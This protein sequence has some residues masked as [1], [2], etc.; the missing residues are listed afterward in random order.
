MRKQITAYLASIVFVGVAP[1]ALALGGILNLTVAAALALSLPIFIAQTGAI[2]YFLSGLKTFQPGLK[3]AYYFF[4]AGLAMFSVGQL[5]LPAV[6][7]LN[8]LNIQTNGLGPLFILYCFGTFVMYI[9]VRKFAKLLQT[10][11]FP[12][13]PLAL[14]VAITAI[15]TGLSWF[16]PHTGADKVG[17]TFFF[18]LL[19]FS[20]ASSMVAALVG[21]R[22]RQV[23]GAAYKPAI[24]WLVAGL[25]MIAFYY[26]QAAF[27]QGIGASVE[28]LKWFDTYN[29][30][31]WPSIAGS[32]FLL[33]AGQLFKLVGLRYGTLP[34]PANELDIVTYVANLP[35]DPR[36]ID[37]IIDTVRRLTASRQTSNAL[38]AVEKAKLLEIYLKIEEYLVTQE[39][40]RKFT[41]Q[42][43]RARL[44]REFQQ[45]LAAL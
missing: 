45:K 27:V 9:G 20:G 3:R 26:F 23:I 12:L 39:T 11:P 15:G 33:R 43:L 42:D 37:P 30:F 16:L 40:L 34:E 24:L 2:W 8:Y 35:S 38:D 32:V 18:G 1:F 44:P 28:F 41:R 31:L 7:V 21:W 5:S 10:K 36:A 25:G 17:P 14:I 13:P 4:V 29:I 22:I 19:F 6:V